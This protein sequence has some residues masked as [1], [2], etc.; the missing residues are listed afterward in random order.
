MDPA[1]WL[2][3]FTRFAVSAQF[4]RFILIELRREGVVRPSR[5]GTKK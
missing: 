1:M 3:Y 4:E 5:R 2:H